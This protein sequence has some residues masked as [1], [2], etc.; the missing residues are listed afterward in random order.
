MSR[1]SIC[2]YAALML[3]GAACSLPVASMAQVQTLPAPAPAPAPAPEG[4]VGDAIEVKCL[5]VRDLGLGVGRWLRRSSKQAG[6]QL[7]AEQ[8][9]TTGE[10]EQLGGTTGELTGAGDIVLGAESHSLEQAMQTRKNQP[11]NFVLFLNGIGLPTDS[12]LIAGE[13]VRNLTVLRYRLSQGKELQLLW[14][15]IFADKG[16]F[17]PQDLYGALGWQPKT[18]PLTV[19][20]TRGA[21]KAQVAITTSAQFTI[22]LLFVLITIALAVYMARGT[23]AMRDADTPAWWDDA[24]AK[25]RLLRTMKDPVARDAA[26]K[27]VDP[28]YDR[29]NDKTYLAAAEA[30]LEGRPVASTDVLATTVGLML[31]K[32]RW[33]PVRGS[34][35]LSRTQLVLWFT[36]SVATGLFL[37]LLYGD[38]RRIDG[39]LLWLLGIS[40]GT[41]GVSWAADRDSPVQGVYKPSKGFWVDVLTGPDDRGQVH[42]FQAV[43][44]N[45]LLLIVGIFHVAQQ[46]S[47]PVFDSSW[48]IF[49]GISGSA[50]GLGK[51]IVENR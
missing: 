25:W 50:Y 26:L 32:K 24:V 29:Q 40:V 15:T 35:S 8:S 27:K 39:S 33:R 10:C 1:L 18:G 20:P 5:L 38:L 23:D 44:I 42:R 9:G 31:C 17:E 11:G 3:A 12:Q 47:Y 14:S 22:A 48:L 30:A 7:Q 6:T 16:L 37:W 45:L 21:A 19:F 49:L 43:V 13:R 41:A 46:L 51:G 28:N 4:G 36:F 2:T 34:Y